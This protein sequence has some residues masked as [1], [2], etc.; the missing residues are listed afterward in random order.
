MEEESYRLIIAYFEKTIDDPG[1]T[2][3]QEWI[4]EN[5]EHLEQ[6]IE[7]IEVLESSKMYLKQ[8]GRSASTWSIISN[9]IGQHKPNNTKAK[10]RYWL[11]CAAVCLFITLAG[12][13]GYQQLAARKLP[14]I[15]YAEV[16]NPDGQHSKVLLP[17]S[18]VI[19]LG[20]GSKLRYA[21]NFAGEKRTV[22]LNG[23]AFFDVIHNSRRPFVVKSGEIETVVLG[24]S[25]NIKAFG[26]EKRVVVTVN[27]G[28][29][30]VMTTIN[31]KEQLIKFLLPNE[32]IEI[33]TQ[34]GLYAFNDTNAEEVSAWIN[35]DFVF[36]NSSL[37]DIAA[38]LQYRYGVKIEFT[39]PELGNV[40]LTAKFRNMPLNQVTENLGL[41]SGLAF[42]HKGNHIFITNNNQKGG[43]I[44]K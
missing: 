36:Y 25:F 5:P 4:E 28:K 20:G 3:L 26:V 39:D 35:N 7:T 18:S 29:V 31:G 27:T 24:T 44:M 23:E 37:R 16:S 33:N 8:S 17:D 14:G 13:L 34:N 41:L 40:R 42:T 15:E 30:G 43:K 38:S 10:Y 2:R 32:Q 12:F 11:G 22:Y 6:F 19:Y 1:L 9:H 21:K